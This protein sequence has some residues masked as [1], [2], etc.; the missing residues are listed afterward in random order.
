MSE[1]V[2]PGA[3]IDCISIS[4]SSENLISAKEVRGK[5]IVVLVAPAHYSLASLTPVSVCLAG[6]IFSGAALQLK[7]EG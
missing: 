2:V 4:M 3:S 1:P 5:V 6:G 7:I